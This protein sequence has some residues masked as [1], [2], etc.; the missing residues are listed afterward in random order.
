[1]NFKKRRKKK[2]NLIRTNKISINL[3]KIQIKLNKT[4]TLVFRHDVTMLKAITN[5]PTMNNLKKLIFI[6]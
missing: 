3:E 6:L 1:M 5:R 2:D 4:K